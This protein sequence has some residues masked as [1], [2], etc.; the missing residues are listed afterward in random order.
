M[1][2]TSNFHPEPVSHRRMNL[3][4]V[5]PLALD[6]AG[7]VNILRQGFQNSFLLEVETEGAHPAHQPTLPVP[8]SNQTIGHPGRV[9]PEVRPL[10]LLIDIYSPH[11]LRRLSP[12]ITATRSVGPRRERVGWPGQDCQ[13]LSEAA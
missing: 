4:Q 12:I 3:V 5:E 1:T 11:I 10:W 13:V 8:D 2:Q 6:I 9:P 7:L